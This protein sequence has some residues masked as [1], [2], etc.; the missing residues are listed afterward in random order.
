MNAVKV[1]LVGMLMIHSESV[2]HASSQFNKIT[3]K[4]L[5][6]LHLYLSIQNYYNLIHL[7][8]H[9]TFEPKTCPHQ[10]NYLYKNEWA[11]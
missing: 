8:F 11:V 5:N 3:V 4:F 7:S 1:L 6:Y 9:C 2:L 10:Y